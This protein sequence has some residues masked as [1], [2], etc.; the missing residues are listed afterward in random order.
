M[1]DFRANIALPVD[2][3]GA[4][5]SES[6]LKRN[7]SRPLLIA[8]TYSPTRHLQRQQL[9]LPVLRYRAMINSVS[10]PGLSL[11]PY[12]NRYTNDALHL[13]DLLSFFSPN[14]KATLTN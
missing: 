8:P 1:T 3:I 10:A 2:A 6:E 4:P 7:L 5:T 14:S 12:F 11:R 9:D 13:C